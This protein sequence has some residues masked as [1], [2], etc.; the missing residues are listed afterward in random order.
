[1]RLGGYAKR[2]AFPA[3][4]EKKNKEGRNE[5]MGSLIIYASK[6]GFTK[7]YAEWLA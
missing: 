2:K 6:T 7:R 5:K 1:M 4:K 3:S